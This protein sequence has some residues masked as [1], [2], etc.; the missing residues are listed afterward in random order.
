MTPTHNAPQPNGR[1]QYFNREL[2]WLAFNQRVLEQSLS[3]KYPLL[4]R[5]RFLSFVSSNLDQFYEI[6]VAGVLQQVDAGRLET[7]FDG[8]GPRELL[9]R[10][11]AGCDDMVKEQY[12]CW[13]EVLLPELQKQRIHFKTV[14]ELSPTDFKWLESY[15]RREVYPVLTRATTPSPQSSRTPQS[16]YFFGK[17]TKPMPLCSQRSMAGFK[18]RGNFDRLVHG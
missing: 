7:D 12:R 6:R 17:R 1:Y 9:T 15:F 4:E 13:K 5:I 18:L 16:S 10:I 2:S 11:R 8:I 3:E 14:E